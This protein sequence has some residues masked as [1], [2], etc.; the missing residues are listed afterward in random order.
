[1]ITKSIAKS[2]EEPVVKQNEDLLFASFFYDDFLGKMSVKNNKIND[3]I[4]LI[5]E[6]AKTTEDETLMHVFQGTLNIEQK[7]NILESQ[8]YRERQRDTYNEEKKEREVQLLCERYIQRTMQRLM[9]LSRIPVAQKQALHEKMR[10][11]FTGK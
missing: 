9:K 11:V 5:E 6:L 1:M 8:L 7:E 4:T 10:K 2:K 3:L